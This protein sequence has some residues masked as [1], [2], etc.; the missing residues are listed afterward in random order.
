[1]SILN[2][3]IGPKASTESTFTSSDWDPRFLADAI[4]NARK[5]LSGTKVTTQSAMRL[6]PYFACIKIISED[7]AKLPFEPFISEDGRTKT[8][9]MDSDAF[10]LLKQPNS[11]MTA[12]SFYETLIQYKLA[13]GNG[14]AHMQRNKGGRVVNMDLVH[15]A[16]CKMK[17]INGQIFYE[18]HMSDDKEELA[19]GGNTLSVETELIPQEDMLHIKGIGNG[20][21]GYSMAAGIMRET[22]GYGMALRDFG[23][24]FFGNSANGGFVL[25]H[26]GVLSEKA[27][28][29]LKKSVN[30]GQIGPMN[31][32]KL[33]VLEEGMKLERI[34]IPPNE[35][36]FLESMNFSIEEL[37][38]FFRMPLSKLQ[39]LMKANFNTLEQQNLDYVTDTLHPHMSS[40]EQEFDWKIFSKKER[41]T[42]FTRFN[43]N[44]L[45]RG[46][47][48]DRAAYL[49]SQ[50]DIGAVSINEVR[51]VEDMN[52]LPNKEADYHWLQLNMAPVEEYDKAIEEEEPE[53]VKAEEDGTETEPVEEEPPVQGENAPVE[54]ESAP[55]PKAF[56][57]GPVIRYQAERMIDREI[58]AFK[59]IVKKGES[60]SDIYKHYVNKFLSGHRVAVFESFA[61]VF[62]VLGGNKADLSQFCVDYMDNEANLHERSELKGA[63][64]EASICDLSVK[65]ENLITKKGL[66]NNEK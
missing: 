42:H 28:E 30:E 20:F 25:S 45:L 47:Q 7:L 55:E 44:E 63:E 11:E 40:I 51:S 66:K 48:K 35:A 14:L 34:T 1:M 39:H 6:A 8:L 31:A 46:N 43:A 18:V 33:K 17:R 60:G 32:H 27:K 36:Q 53:P 21:W 26:P 4:S 29:G 3:I 13:W 10:M 64:K 38:R 50:F 61:P 52:P 58:N 19:F 2:W 12:F 16:R 54:E 9:A 57:M 49:K 56:D 5:T 15:P 65:I 41:R 23:A 59:S 37:A 62:E 24:T 22:I